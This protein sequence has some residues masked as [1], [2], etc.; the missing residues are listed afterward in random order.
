MACQQRLYL[1]K[2]YKNLKW[3]SIEWEFV[4]FPK[5]STDFLTAE[6]LVHF[7]ILLF[8]LM[9]SKMTSCWSAIVLL[10]SSFSLGKDNFIT[11][12]FIFSLSDF[13]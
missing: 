4:L 13:M 1:Q 8:V 5:I 9:A 10:I 6:Q 2:S 12:F 7:N 3:Q 11:Q